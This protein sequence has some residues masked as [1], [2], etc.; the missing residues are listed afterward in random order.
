MKNQNK[1]KRKRFKTNEEYLKFDK[2]DKYRIV[3]VT[4]K[5]NMIICDY[6]RK[7]VN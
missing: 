7:E 3:Q 1:L 6:E 2:N 5:N 4:I